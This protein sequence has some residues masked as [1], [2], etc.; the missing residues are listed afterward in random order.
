[1]EENNEAEFVIHLAFISSLRYVCELFQFH[2]ALKSELNEIPSLPRLD[3]CKIPS[4]IACPFSAMSP[5]VHI[6]VIFCP[7][8]RWEAPLLAV[9]PVL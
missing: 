1:M 2:M 5:P 3:S 8:G 4:C 9:H 6:V 7:S